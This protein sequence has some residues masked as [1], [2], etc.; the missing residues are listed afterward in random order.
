LI[1]E[2]LQFLDLKIGSILETILKTIVCNIKLR[3]IKW[4]LVFV[5]MFIHY[6]N[7]MQRTSRAASQNAQAII[8]ATAANDD[9]E[10]GEL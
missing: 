7:T 6:L 2:S 8:A 1:E 9:E 10:E 5:Y 3:R 4:W